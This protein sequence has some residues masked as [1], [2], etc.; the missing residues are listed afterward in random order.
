MLRLSLALGLLA[1]SALA[2]GCFPEDE[3][4]PPGELFGEYQIMGTLR[5]HECGEAAVPLEL[6]YQPRVQI[7]RFD[8]GR[9]YLLDANGEAIDGS[10]GKD[11][12]FYFSS[13]SESEMFPPDPDE[14]FGHP[15]CALVTTVTF[16]GAADRAPLFEEGEE[17]EDLEGALDG[18][19]RTRI[20]PIAG[21][22]C[23][24]LLAHANQGG[25]F[26]TLPCEI[27]L[28]L[29]GVG[30]GRRAPIDEEEDKE[31]DKEEDE[32]ASGQ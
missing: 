20:A 24:P 13:Q 21:S 12:G 19:L 5:A 31:E 14:F 1:G 2:A 29:E 16:E 22:D 3:S 4:E 26:R 7:R 23:S 32:P 11:G 25:A 30:I 10:V 15:G 9:A 6:P 17:I 27:V 28:D 18:L 8:T